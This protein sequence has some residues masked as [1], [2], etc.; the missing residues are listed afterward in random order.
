MSS[1]SCR[2]CQ[3]DHHETAQHRCPFC[4]ELGTHRGQFCPNAAHM[5]DRIQDREQMNGQYNDLSRGEL[6]YLYALDLTFEMFDDI[7]ANRPIPN[8][9]PVTFVSAEPIANNVIDVPAEPI[10]NDVIEAPA[11]VP[12]VILAN[13]VIEVHA[14]PITNHIPNSATKKVEKDSSCTIT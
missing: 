10:T 12:I 13:P 7:A 2:L 4:Y 11:I 6:D 9:D 5:Y 14:E 1:T 8:P 3:Q